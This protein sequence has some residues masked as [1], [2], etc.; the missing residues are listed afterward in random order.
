MN[1]R[2]FIVSKKANRINEEVNKDKVLSISV[3]SELFER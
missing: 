1:R 2:I 3:N